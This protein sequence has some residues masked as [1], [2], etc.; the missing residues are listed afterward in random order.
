[1]YVT[2]MNF[3]PQDRVLIA[4]FPIVLYAKSKLDT[5]KMQDL[6]YLCRQVDCLFGQAPLV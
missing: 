4:F 6:E 3:T 2:F 1:M 5:T